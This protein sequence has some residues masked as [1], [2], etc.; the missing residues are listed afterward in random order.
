MSIAKPPLSS[1]W[2]HSAA[3]G[4]TG[5]AD[6]GGLKDTGWTGASACPP[7]SWMNWILNKCDAA[8]RYIIA[9]GIP[10]YDVNESYSVGDRVQWGGGFGRTYVCIVATVGNGTGGNSPGS[11][12]SKWAAW[13][14]GMP[15]YRADG[16][17]EPGDTVFAANGLS[18]QCLLSNLHDSAHEPSASP[19]YWE[20]WGHTDQ[21]ILDSINANT[22]IRFSSAI[23]G[24]SGMS[25]TSGSFSS[26]IQIRMGN[27]TVYKD[28]SFSIADA[29]NGYADVALS[30]SSAFASGIKNAQFTPAVNTFG[31]GSD[32]YVEITGANTIRV[33]CSRG[34]G[35][36]WSGY[37]RLLGY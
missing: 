13:G 34:N 35:P 29:A 26:T 32:A 25:I 1:I 2:A 22:P 8:A 15:K 21:D 20:R 10:D 24:L 31:G 7:F 18:Y 3:S 23:G 17:Y 5:I 4:D 33:H 37:V 11:D 27:D 9:R 16:D 19:T 30:G 28:L 6:P 36:G 12:A 14:R